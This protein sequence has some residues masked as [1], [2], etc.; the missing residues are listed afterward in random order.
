MARILQ[1]NLQRYTEARLAAL[2]EALDDLHNAASE[3][4]TAEATTL[5]PQDL[6]EWLKDVIYTAQETLDELDASADAAPAY[7]PNIQLVR[8]SS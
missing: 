2:L 8:K 4:S 5:S 6:R 7:E 3:G 1:P